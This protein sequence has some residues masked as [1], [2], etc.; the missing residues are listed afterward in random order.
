[1][2][3][4]EELAM[5]NDAINMSLASNKRM[6]NSKP[7]FAVIFTDIETKLNALKIKINTPTPIKNK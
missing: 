3:T 5:L 7:Q 4:Q 2:F 6:A 1:M